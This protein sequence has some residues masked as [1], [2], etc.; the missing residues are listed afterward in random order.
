M[1]R[2]TPEHNLDRFADRVG[3]CGLDRGGATLAG[4]NL[5]HMLTRNAEPLTNLAQLD[6]FSH[7]LDLAVQRF[8]WHCWVTVS[9]YG[10]KVLN[11][12]TAVKTQF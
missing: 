12:R 2:R 3:Y 7:Q 9:G 10:G 6:L 4:Y 8:H 11:N 5:R 1:L